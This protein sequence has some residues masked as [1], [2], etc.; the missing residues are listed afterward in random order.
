MGL[1]FFRLIMSLWVIDQH[2]KWSITTI[3]PFIVN[4]LGRE[5]FAY[6]GLGHAAVMSFFVLSGYVI[7]WV[8]QNKYPT[9]RL[10]IK[11][12]FVG[13]F[14]RIYPLYWV[15][16]T[17]VVIGFFLAPG[18]AADY[19]QL[20]PERIACDYMLL[21]YAFIGFFHFL[22]QYAYGMIDV[23]AW[24]LPYDLLFYL[25]APWL[26][27]RKKA[28]LAVILYELAYLAA[29]AT[30]GTNDFLPWHEGYLTTG[31]AAM[32]AFAVGALSY[33]YRDIRIPTPIIIA[34]VALQLYVVFIPYG[35]TNYYLNHLLN[36]GASVIL[37]LAF[38]KRSK[39][40]NLLG[41]LT[42]S[43]YLL[44]VPLLRL[45]EFI[46]LPFYSVF[47][48]IAT[49]GL[50]FATVKYFETPVERKRAAVTR[51]MLGDNP[52]LTTLPARGAKLVLGLLAALLLVSGIHNILE[53]IRQS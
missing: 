14:L 17:V 9:D 11:A 42:Y 16:L 33:Y 49:Y 34:M 32:L 1:G 51:N 15:I 21:P 8:L 23:P 46:S 48:L 35:L 38:K 24:T 6:I 27:L 50:S 39:L 28:L 12:F 29:I 45:F 19:P 36:I 10:G 30:W 22:N 13:R 20:K 47:A 53:L 43:T 4:R 37:V 25:I 31:H 2:Y 5:N 52:Q 18:P 44:H 26:V 7:T 3:Q 41:E 40:D